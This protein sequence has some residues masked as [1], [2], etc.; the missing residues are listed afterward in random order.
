MEDKTQLKPGQ[1]F[2]FLILEK[3]EPLSRLELCFV[4]HKIAS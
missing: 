2:I 1:R 3:D 4:F